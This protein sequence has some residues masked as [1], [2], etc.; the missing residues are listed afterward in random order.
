[1]EVCPDERLPQPEVVPTLFRLVEKSLIRLGATIRGGARYAMLQTIREYSLNK[2]KA[3]PGAA[4]LHMRHALYFSAMASPTE[5]TVRSPQQVEWLAQLEEEHDNFR[6]A[7]E[8]ALGNEPRLALEIASSLDEFWTRRHIGEGRTWVTRAMEAAKPTGEL[9]ARA[10]EVAGHLAWLTGDQESAFAL[11]GEAGERWTALGNVP[12]AGHAMDRL[13][14]GHFASGAIELGMEQMHRAVEMLRPA[15]DK[16]RLV[17]ALNNLGYNLA[18]IGDA[19]TAK[20]VLDEAL[21]LARQFGDPHAVSSV[22]DSIAEVEMSLGRFNDARARWQECFAIAMRL[23]DKRQIAYLLEARARLALREADPELCIRLASAGEAARSSIGEVAPQ[24]W[25]EIVTKT[26]EA[27]RHQLPALTAET[28]WR[29]GK[30]M[31]VEEAMAS[32]I[33]S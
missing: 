6:T 31:T 3:S 15:G 1:M 14:A 30:A 28:A 19:S 12:R 26:V 21:Q 5:A 4:D 20:P 13:G 16:W 23:D 11:I 29:E 2:L 25:R 24:D 33:A 22:L 7:I 8:W 17:S 9:Q 32:V 18:L 27:A 10:T